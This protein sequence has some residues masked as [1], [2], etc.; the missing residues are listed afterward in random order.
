AQRTVRQRDDVVLGKGRK[1]FADKA[2]RVDQGQNALR[3]VLIQGRYFQRARD[4]GGTGAVFVACG[5]KHFAPAQFPN[6]ARSGQGVAFVLVKDG[7]GCTVA[8]GA[9][10]AGHTHRASSVVNWLIV[11]DC[12]STWAEISR[13]A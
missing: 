8:Y 6:T 1:Q 3:T 4:E 12:A 13:R 9:I 2:R 11:A 10:H 5:K 7:A